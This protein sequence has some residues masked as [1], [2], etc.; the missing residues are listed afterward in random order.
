MSDVIQLIQRIKEL[1]SDV[2]AT[3]RHREQ[4]D[5]VV[6]DGRRLSLYCWQKQAF[7]HHANRC[8]LWEGGLDA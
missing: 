3:C 1:P 7:T 2:C 8:D 6:S 5:P 4:T